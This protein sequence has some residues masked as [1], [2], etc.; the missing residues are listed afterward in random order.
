MLIPK[1]LLSIGLSSKFHSLLRQIYRHLEPS[2]IGHTSRLETVLRVMDVAKEVFIEGLGHDSIVC[3]DNSTSLQAWADNLEGRECQRC[4]DFSIRN[5]NK[6]GVFGV[7]EA[8]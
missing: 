6:I 7:S 1:L 8:S 5:I 2:R 4:P 3:E